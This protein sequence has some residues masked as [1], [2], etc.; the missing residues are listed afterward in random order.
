ML[1]LH[2]YKSNRLENLA[3][4]LIEVTTQPLSHPLTPETIVVQSLG[5]GRWLA[6]SLAQSSGV[7]LNV[8]FPFP[9]AF[10]DSLF[11]NPNPTAE[12]PF[13]TSLLPWRILAAL[14]SH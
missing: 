12:S 13:S 9:A 11:P 3:T 6:Q 7:A 1:G 4:A 8:R 10:A 2:L 14:P 5:M